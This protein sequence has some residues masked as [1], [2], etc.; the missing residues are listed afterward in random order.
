MQGQLFLRY[1]PPLELEVSVH[2]FTE[3]CLPV[4]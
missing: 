1:K 3:S 4:L 2:L